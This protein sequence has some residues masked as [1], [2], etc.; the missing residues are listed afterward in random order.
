[1]DQGDGFKQTVKVTMG[2]VVLGS[3]TALMNSQWKGVGGT[4]SNPCI[5]V[6]P[7]NDGSTVHV[8]ETKFAG[9]AFG[10]LTITNDVPSYP[11]KP[12]TYQFN[13][14][15][16]IDSAMGIGYAH[17]ATCDGL[18]PGI[19]INPNWGTSAQWGPV[20]IVVA[21]AEMQSPAFPNGD[22]SKLAYP[23]VLDKDGF[24]AIPLSLYAPLMPGI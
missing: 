7:A 23:L 12:Q 1:V 16:Q 4:G 3:D 20:P 17:G 19:R 24:P 9:Y 18:H 10:T 14:A 2:P 6:N 11:A 15:Y 22:P 8:L 13:L 5:D 21:I